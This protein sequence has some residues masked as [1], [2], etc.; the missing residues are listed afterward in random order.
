M[1]D[2]TNTPA[3]MS[4]TG[5]ELVMEY[6]FNAPRELVFE[7][8]SKAEHLVNWWG[9][10]GWTLPVC[11]MDFRPGGA[12]HYCMKGME[13]EESWGKAIYQE[14]VRPERIVYQDY[15]S[16]AEGTLREDIVG[17]KVTLEF[18]EQGNKTLVTT[19]AL[20]PS[21]D[22]L[23]AS[24]AMGMVEGMNETWGRLVDY[25]KSIA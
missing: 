17:S 22:A 25:L 8:W 21:V 14:I 16:D 20:F 13:G 2:K 5:Q 4:K 19:R 15:F 3:K 9:P 10:Q 11:T 1:T 23:E 6:T 7:M 12:W 18:S 24:V